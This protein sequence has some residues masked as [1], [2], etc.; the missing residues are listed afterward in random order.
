MEKKKIDNSLN[1]EIQRDSRRPSYVSAND[2]EIQRLPVYTL[3]G[4]AAALRYFDIQAVDGCRQDRY[5]VHRPEHEMVQEQIRNHGSGYPGIVQMAWMDP[6]DESVKIGAFHPLRFDYLVNEISRQKGILWGKEKVSENPRYF[7]TI[8]GPIETVVEGYKESKRYREFR[9]NEFLF[10]SRTEMTAFLTSLGFDGGMLG[11]EFQKAVDDTDRASYEYKRAGKYWHDPLHS[12][13]SLIG[14]ISA[15]SLTPH[16]KKLLV[17]D[18]AA[19]PG[20]WEG[21]TRKACKDLYDKLV[22]YMEEEISDCM[23]KIEEKEGCEGEED[24][25][26]SLVYRKDSL[27]FLLNACN[28][29]KSFFG[30][31]DYIDMVKDK[32]MELSLENME[33]LVSFQQKVNEKREE[34]FS[35]IKEIN[36]QTI[37]GNSEK[38]KRIIHAI[39]SLPWKL[40]RYTH[41]TPNYKHVSS[42]QRLQEKNEVGGTTFAFDI[43]CLRNDAFTFYF[44]SIDNKVMKSST[45]SGKITYTEYEFE[46]IP[47]MWVSAD[48][49]ILESEDTEIPTFKGSGSKVKALII[50]YFVNQASKASDF[51]EMSDADLI[52]QIVINILKF[53]EVKVPMKMGVREWMREGAEA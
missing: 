18:T 22:G 27:A 45:F 40:R 14:E 41:I 8:V 44:I 30:L 25:V 35:F 31:F 33:Y 28:K 26:S 39:S 50:S 49:I 42:N 11:T 1:K 51:E 20:F 17:E 24:N 23:Q 21:L 10:F 3:C 9:N 7:Y 5:P 4:N 37:S 13:E 19:D 16:Y 29:S 38:V 6:S 46:R 12:Y 2:P 34:R 48:M 53:G 52:S 36:S 47:D 32:F 15:E 43:L